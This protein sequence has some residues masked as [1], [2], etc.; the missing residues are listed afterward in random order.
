LS[1]ERRA[2]R[3]ARPDRAVVRPHIAEWFGHRIFPVV[4]ASD[5]SIDDQRAGRCPFLTQTLKRS[6]PC[7]K[8]PN[9]RGVCTISA[10]SNGPRQ[11]W[12]VCP[13]RALDDGLLADMVGCVFLSGVTFPGV[14]VM[15]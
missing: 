10:T 5:T 7:V 13:Y 4:S 11:D 2:A 9:S 3:V 1:P 12:L 8:A 15:R 14:P 6:A